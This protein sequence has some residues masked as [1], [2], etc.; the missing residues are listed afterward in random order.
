MRVILNPNVL[1]MQAEI[2]TLY[3]TQEIVSP[4]SF[5]KAV[6]VECILHGNGRGTEKNE[7]EQREQIYYSM[8]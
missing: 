7:I 4:D 6:I 8:Y 1:R 3:R 5:Q 2:R